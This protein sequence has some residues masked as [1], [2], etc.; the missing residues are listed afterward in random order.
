MKVDIE[1]QKVDIRV[2]NVLSQIIG[3]LEPAVHQALRND[4]SYVV[5]G[6][7]FSEYSRQG[8]WDGTKYLYNLKNQ[9]FPTGLLKRAV[10]TLSNLG[11]KV[12]VIDER[13]IP[14]GKPLKLHG[15]TLRDYQEDAVK[16][17]IAKT[18]G[19]L[20]AGTGSGKC[21]KYGTKILMY[22]GTIKNVEDI[23]VGDLVM[24]MDSKPRTVGEVHKG[25]EMLYKVQH[26]SGTS[27][28]VT[29]NHIL[30]GMLTGF[31]HNVTAPNG[32][33]YSKGDIVDISVDEWFKASKTFKHVFKGFSTK[34]ESF[35]KPIGNFIIDPYVFG[36]WLGDGNCNSMSITTMDKEVVDTWYSLED[37]DL[38]IRVENQPHNKSKTYHLRAKIGKP[39]KYTSELKRLGV[40]K[41]THIPDVYKY[42]DIESRRK[43]LAG[44]LD[45]DGYVSGNAHDIIQKSKVL[46][47]DICF[48]ARS[49]GLSVHQTT[50]ICKCQTGA[51]G[52][53][54]RLSITG[55]FENIPFKVKRRNVKQK[56]KY[57]RKHRLF[58]INITEDGVGKYAGFSVLEDDKHF[59]LGDFT[60]VHNSVCTAGILAKLGVRSLVIVPTTILLSQTAE[61]LHK[62]LN[63]PIGMVG[64]GINNI[65]DIT[66]ATFQSLTDSEDTKKS[67][68]DSTDGRWK[69]VVKKQ[70]V[71]REDLRP[72]LESLDC[73]IVDECFPG[74]TRVKT[75]DGYKEI[76]KIVNQKLPIKVY[77]FNTKNQKFELKPVTNYYKKKAPETL[78]KVMFGNHSAVHS[79]PNHPYYVLRNNK[80][81]KVRADELVIGDFVISMPR[82]GT[83][84]DNIT[85][86]VSKT[87]KQVL[88]GSI[89]GDGSL[90]KET[91]NCRVSF[92]QG[93]KQLDYLKWKLE[94]L[95]DLV[96]GKVREGKSGYCDNKVYS[97]S[98]RIIKELNI[99]NVPEEEHVKRVLQNIDDLGV[100]VWFMDDGSNYCGSLTIHTE[101]FSYNS[102]LLFQ[103]FFKEKYGLDTH[104]SKCTKN[105][106]VYYFLVFT[107]E[108]SKKLSSIIGQYVPEIMRYKL[109]GGFGEPYNFT[110]VP[111]L[112]YGLSEITH[113][114]VEK[115]KVPYVYNI[116]V[117]DNHNYLVGNNK[118]VSNCHHM[119]SD[120]IQRVMA[121]CTNA[122]YR[123]GCSATP[124]SNRDEDV[125]I[126]AA[127]GRV[128]K[129]I[130]ASYL[131]QN[132]WLSKPTIHL[133]PFKQQRGGESDTYAGLYEEKITKN[134]VRNDLLRRIIEYRADL[135]DSVLVS[136]RYLEHG[137]LLYDSLVDKYGKDVVFVNSKVATKK[138]NEAL[139]KLEKKEIK[140]CIGTSL[141]NEG[142]NLPAL[143]TL[144]LAGT[145][146]SKIA[147]MQLVGRVLRKTEN[148]STVDVYDIQDFNCKYF[149]SASKE[150]REIYLSESEFV[151]Q[152]D[153]MFTEV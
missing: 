111:E 29:R 121:A 92:T 145:P 64:D 53:Y 70:V 11:Y 93:Y 142:V 148:K 79:T 47:D 97:T 16:E 82:S 39:N 150:R 120:S 66:V 139:E 94:L 23:A 143:N 50:K 24:G 112:Y 58:G 8:M 12:N 131:I 45:S 83:P 32:K 44:I 138:L 134:P 30:T 137:K 34:V 69:K 96:T 14:S 43:L 49:L 135:G 35:N 21:F 78:L 42:S 103:Q 109:V 1:P 108:S 71:I 3:R 141:I 115:S 100:A 19:L 116:E 101:S 89:L 27:Y 65:Q 129:E 149:T 88:L 136:V 33:K 117:A 126:E 130:T 114:S 2:N 74:T 104:I 37:A 99:Y 146:K 18:R 22:D 123:Y 31:T 87:Q 17:L 85:P 67:K 55:N 119:I 13:V 59:L 102:Q 52:E 63:V 107:K 68:F 26:I 90:R 56:I 132:G 80:I 110:P 91:N 51:S 25:T 105:H 84:K 46:A 15:V 38:S 147:T 75:E 10:V 77:S 40:Y 73:V 113:I 124:Y 125:L 152:E 20:M 41:N 54:N 36:L 61:V 122:Y 128:V 9:S 133:I 118:L 5:S 86:A 144:V 106:K 140:I 76:S 127:C 95:G 60:V 81:Q 153:N 7:V 28:V 48:L 98:T 6:A 151:L 62:I 4:L 72:Y 57:N